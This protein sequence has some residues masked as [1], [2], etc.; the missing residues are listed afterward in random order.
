MDCE[1]EGKKKALRIDIG[2]LVRWLFSPV[3]M[4]TV[5]C[6]GLSNDRDM[7]AIKIDSESANSIFTISSIAD[8]PIRKFLSAN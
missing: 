1:T 5:R 6:A 3:S 7:M 4:A 8:F 2:Q